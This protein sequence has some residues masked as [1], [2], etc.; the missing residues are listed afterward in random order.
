VA[1]TANAALTTSDR[2]P[3]VNEYWG[4]STAGA[5]ISIT[6]DYGSTQVES[7]SDGKWSARVEYPDAPVGVTFNVHVTSSKGEAAYDFSFT[8]VAPG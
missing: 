5:V 8:R 7:K 3:P 2:T 1:F 6:S 4:T